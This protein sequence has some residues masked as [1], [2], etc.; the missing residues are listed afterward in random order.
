MGFSCFSFNI[1]IDTTA[2]IYCAAVRGLKYTLY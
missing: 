1:R 2:V